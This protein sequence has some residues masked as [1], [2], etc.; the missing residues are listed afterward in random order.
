MT[1][2]GVAVVGLVVVAN[3]AGQVGL[4]TS[5][6]ALVL[7]A[8]TACYALA[9]ITFLLWVTAPRAA[10]VALLLSMAVAATVMRAADPTGPV[11]GLF[12][13]MA[14]APLRLDLREAGPV[15][16]GSALVYNLEQ[17]R[18]AANPAVFALVTD[19]GAAFFF[20]MG[21]LLRREREQRAELEASREAE[22]LAA[23]LAERA[24]LAREVHDALA[25]TLS[26]LALQ[27]EGM[28][29]LARAKGLDD[30]VTGTIDRA[31]AL[32]RSGIADARRAVGALRGDGLPGPDRLPD[33][34]TEH[35]RAGGSCELSIHGEPHPLSAEAGHALY[36]IAQE[37]LSNARKHAPGAAVRMTLSW[38]P[39]VARLVV[40][41]DGRSRSSGTAPGGGHGLRGMGERAELLGGTLLAEPTAAGFRVELTVPVAS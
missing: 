10:V 40:E 31:H 15:A 30:E 3:A 35:R 1:P 36:R 38:E 33:L 29:L 9:A 4:G 23:V 26:G 37:A 12:L 6:P 13:V 34:V 24:R 2:V 22:R 41:D 28:R 7:A 20:L 18:T 27:L 32:T 14:F 19:G 11:V 16:I 5:G 21:W 8:A 25:H 17:A 39:A